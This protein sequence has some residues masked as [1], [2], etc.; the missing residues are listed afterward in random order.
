M[1]LLYPVGSIRSVVRVIIRRL[2]IDLQ[3][4]NSI[5]SSKEKKEPCWSARRPVFQMEVPP[6]IPTLEFIHR[7]L[8]ISNVCSGESGWVVFRFVTMMVW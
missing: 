2:R 1:C 4:R 3:V 6:L 8:S 7:F 5:R